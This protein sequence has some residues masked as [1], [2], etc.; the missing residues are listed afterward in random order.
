MAAPK[1]IAV[2]GATGAQGGGLMEAILSDPN[3]GFVARAIT[4]EPSKARAGGHAEPEKGWISSPQPSGVVHRSHP[5]VR[6]PSAAT[7]MP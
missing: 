7:R 5:L 2:C 4:R 3:G 6:V 1:I